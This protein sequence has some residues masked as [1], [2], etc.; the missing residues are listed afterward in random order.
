MLCAARGVSNLGCKMLDVHSLVFIVFRVLPQTVQCG[1]HAD[2]GVKLI[3]RQSFKGIF[4][5][6]LRQ[7]SLNMARMAFFSW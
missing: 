5:R 1:Q 2:L 6:R 7:R 3:P 4:F